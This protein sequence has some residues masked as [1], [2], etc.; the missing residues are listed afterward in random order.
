MDDL[1]EF[2]AQL[3]TFRPRRPAPLETRFVLYR[4]RKPFWV[5]AAAGL[6]AAIFVAVRLNGPAA[7][8]VGEATERLTLGQMTALAIERPDEFD[9][10]LTRMS[11]ASLPD[12]TRPGGALQRLAVLR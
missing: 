7:V 6:A 8:P 4:S 12:V 3:R 11:R 1:T 2:E 5:V 9:V 10:A